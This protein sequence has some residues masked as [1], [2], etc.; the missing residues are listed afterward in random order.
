MLAHLSSLSGL[1]TSGLGTFLGPLVIWLVGKEKHPFIDRHG[2]EALNFGITVLVALVGA[3]LVALL[4]MIPL[5]MLGPTMM[6]GMLL[7]MPLALGLLVAWIAFVVTAAVK[8]SN[9]QEYR[10]PVSFRFVK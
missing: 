1:F 2:K 4:L 7:F 6:M 3:G 10:Y 5:L 8:A 9:G